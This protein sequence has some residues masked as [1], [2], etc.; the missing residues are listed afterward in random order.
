[1]TD[2]IN[3]RTGDI[4]VS[5][6]RRKPFQLLI[7]PV[8]ADCNLRCAYCFY[9]RAHELYPETKR[10]VM[11]ESVLQTIIQGLL[12]YRFPETV[13]AWQ[14]GEPTLAGLEFFRKAVGFQQQFGLP[15]QIVGNALQTNGV[16]I[17]DEWCQ[18]FS[19]YNFLIGLSI[20]GPQEIHDAKR[21]NVGGHGTWSRAMAAAE[22]MQRWGVEFNVLCVVN[23]D[24]VSLGADLLKWFVKNDFR[25]VQF[26]PCVEKESPFNVSPEDFGKFLCDVFDYWSKDGFGRVS[27]RDFDALLSA[28]IGQPGGL[29]TYGERC[30]A[31]IVVEH[32]GD[33]YPC[34]FFVYAAW[35]LGNVMNAPLHTFFET[36]KYKQFAYQKDKVPAC[37]GCSWRSTCHGGC[38]KDRLVS[39]TRDTPSA[40]CP[41]YKRF[42]AHAHARLNA[43]SK[44]LNQKGISP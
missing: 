41:A 40:L 26:I 3:E 33:V 27:V 32:N 4:G 22:T 23:R 28:R 2:D 15:R 14:G 19:Q 12:S 37:R 34:D 24:N 6:T 13:F 25:F 10:H 16:L 38:Q 29:C 44:R 42:F 11:P 20:D 39:G 18:F 31:Y 7:K 35:K 36:E 1:M 17:D 8:G 5:M 21:R 30:D 9:L 43:L